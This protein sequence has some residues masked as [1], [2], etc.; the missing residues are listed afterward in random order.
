VNLLVYK[1]K[2]LSDSFIETRSEQDLNSW[3]DWR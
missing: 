3:A 1:R 2:S